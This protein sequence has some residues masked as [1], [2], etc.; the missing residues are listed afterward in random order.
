MREEVCCRERK[1]KRGVADRVECRGWVSLYEM[2]SHRMDLGPDVT[3]HTTLATQL[4]S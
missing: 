4:P 1:L 3:R 2:W